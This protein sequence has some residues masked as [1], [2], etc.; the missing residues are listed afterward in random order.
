MIL[1]SIFLVDVNALALL[2]AE[3]VPFLDFAVT[4]ARQLD[5]ATQFRQPQSCAFG[6]SSYFSHAS[7]KPALRTHGSPVSSTESIAAGPRQH[8]DSTLTTLVMCKLT[9]VAEG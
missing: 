3:H 5:V 4:I 1:L 9:H 6:R 2:Y 7:S 8:D